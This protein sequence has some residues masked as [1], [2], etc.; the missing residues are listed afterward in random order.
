VRPTVLPWRRATDDF[1]GVESHTAT[2]V[3]PASFSVA[4]TSQRQKPGSG[5]KPRRVRVSA[6]SAA[7]PGAA[8][9]QMVYYAPLVC[10]PG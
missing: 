6:V 10:P 9:D 8:H 3:P 2:S 4:T 7:F 5:T 1:S